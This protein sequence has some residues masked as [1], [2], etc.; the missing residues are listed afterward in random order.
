MICKPGCS[1]VRKP[2]LRRCPAWRRLSEDQATLSGA[3]RGSSRCVQ[4]SG[5]CS[6][7]VQ[8]V[9]GSS[10]ALLALPV[11]SRWSAVAPWTWTL[12]AISK[13]RAVSET[14]ERSVDLCHSFLSRC[15]R[16]GLLGPLRTGKVPFSELGTPAPSR[17][18]PSAPPPSCS[19]QPVGLPLSFSVYRH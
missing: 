19:L 15:S 3:P 8:Y 5:L 12:P 13:S 17:G 10:G 9:H 7:R 18:P 4:G 6:R 14:S 11:S 2:K 1:M 16:Q